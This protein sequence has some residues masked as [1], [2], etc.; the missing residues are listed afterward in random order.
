[1]QN[2]IYTLVVKSTLLSEDR[3]EMAI[4]VPDGYVA[5]SCTVGYVEQN[6][7]LARVRTNAPCD[8][9][10]DFVIKFAKK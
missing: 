7:N 8:G 6:G 4:Y 1:M 2:G 9:E 5:E 3:Y 10:Y